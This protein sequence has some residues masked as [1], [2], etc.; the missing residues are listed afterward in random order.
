MEKMT[1]KEFEEY[2]KENS[3]N[4]VRTFD[5]NLFSLS[6]K[7]CGSDDVCIVNTLEVEDIQSGCYTCGSWLEKEGAV[8]IKC[9]GCGN[10]MTILKGEDVD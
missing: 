7:K 9:C 2:C 10:A 8:I 5:K 1:L 3:E 4:I 6:C